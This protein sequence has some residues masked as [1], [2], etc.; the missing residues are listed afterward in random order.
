MSDPHRFIPDGY[1]PLVITDNDG[2]ILISVFVVTT[3]DG[4]KVSA[5]LARR[6]NP[7]ETWSTPIEAEPQ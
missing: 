1:Y 4:V 7:W 2:Q 5:N 6:S 3:T